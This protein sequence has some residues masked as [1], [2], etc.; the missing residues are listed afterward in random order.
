M[1]NDAAHSTGFLSRAHCPAC[2]TLGKEVFRRPYSDQ[3]IRAALMDFYAQVG[4]LD[5]ASIV[6]AKYS[7]AACPG[8]RSYFQSEIPADPLLGRLYEEWI[9]PES[10]RARF[11]EN[12]AP[13]RSFLLAK[14]VLLSLSQLK[15]GAPRTALDYGCGWG[16]WSVMTKG[17]GLESW[18][19]ELSP[20]RRDNAAGLG[21]RVVEEDNLPTSYFGLINL[22]QVLE[23]VPAPQ[24]CLQ[25]L[26]KRLHPDGVLRLAVPT[27][28]R[29]GRALKNFDRE[30]LRPSLGDLNAIAPLEHLN[31]FSQAGLLTLAASVGLQRIR[32][33]WSDM[34]Q[35]TVF[36]PG[37]LS[38]I[39]AV[40]LP[41]YLR[42]RFTN[43][44][45]F[46]LKPAQSIPGFK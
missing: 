41:F 3:A 21:I 16:E 1:T 46:R 7:V 44:L 4:A 34:I 35:A 2:G 24:E 22:D 5:Y 19:T 12:R 25:S 10:A 28:W 13:F 26:A 29:V 39:K 27:P 42:S 32:P 30:I 6:D 45:Y 18:G 8:C 17:F 14:E 20:T 36:S 33:N 23:H 43:Q 15:P 31:A 40:L 11:H 38:K 9:D 37:V